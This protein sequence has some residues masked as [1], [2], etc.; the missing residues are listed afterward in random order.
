MSFPLLTTKLYMPPIR[1][2]LVPRPQLMKQ[3]NEGS[4]RRLIL[5]SAPAGFGKTTL[6]S[7]WIKNSGNPVAWISLD[8]GDNDPARFL[9]YLV[10]ALRTLKEDIGKGAL[11][12]LQ[13]PQP[14]DSETLLTAL[15]NEINTLPERLVLVLDDYHLVTAKQVHNAVAFL[16]DHLPPH[17]L[18]VLATRADPPLPIARLRGRG[19][20]TELR[21]TDL[22][23]SLDEATAFLRQVTGLDLCSEDVDALTTR[24]EGWITGL[25]MAALALQAA[26]PAERQDADQVASFVQAFT[27]SNRYVLDYLV[28]EVLQRQPEKIQSF[29]LQTAILDRLTGPLCDAVLEI[30][31]WRLDANLDTAQPAISRMQY[32]NSRSPSPSQE[33]LEQL[34]A[35]NLF[36]VPLDNERRWYR[37]HRL[38]TDL[39]RKRLQYLQPEQEPILHRRASAWL[40]EHGLVSEAIG[41]AL[42]AEDYER[43]ADLIERV[44]EATLGRSELVT[45]LGWVD[46]L[47]DELVQARP[48]LGLLHAWALMW[49]GQPL[50][51]IESRLQDLDTGTEAASIRVSA[52]RSFL[53]TWQGRLSR[54]GAMAQEAL[55]Q[56][57]EG[58]FFLRSIAAWNVGISLLLSGEIEAGSQAFEEVARMGL[59]AGNVLMSVSAL[60]HLAELRMSQAAYRE[61]EG[62]YRRALQS[63]LDAQGRPLP[64]GG[65]AL[66]GLGEISREWNELETA[67]R[68]VTEGIECTSRWGDFG[69]LDGYIAMARIRQAQ[70]DVQG[71]RD[72]LQKAQRIALLF[73]VTDLDDLVVAIHQVRLWLAQGDVE[74]AVHWLA[75]RGYS[76]AEA[77]QTRAEVRLPE[78]E[79]ADDLI[80]RHMRSYEDLLMART[81]LALD[82]P[83]DALPLLD[84]HI[85][86]L[87]QQGRR[88]SRRM[89]EVLSQKAL[90][91][92]AQGDV[93][94]A[95]TC[96]ESALS[97]A[98]PGGLMRIFVDEGEPML[99]LLRQAAARGIALGYVRQLI[100]AYDL[101][102]QAGMGRAPGDTH[103]PTQ[104]MQPLVEPLSKREM[105]VLRLLATGMS[106]PEIANEL[107]IATSTVRSHLKNIY[108]KLDVHKRW[109]A[110]HR[111]EELGLL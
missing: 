25:Q 19:Q 102:A 48:S 53:A 108:G 107:Y 3:L 89:I 43:G 56:L 98:E 93:D 100:A 54:A 9:A 29:L 91:L 96:L 58:E 110:V 55:E 61:A 18:V 103:T 69:A 21:Q 109:D 64:I 97:I 63:A 5:I 77:P 38:F 33:I 35:A 36:I 79:K 42:S 94:Q 51:S 17:V 68:Y 13:S 2:E 6:I 66:I 104:I 45:F 87:E 22:R 34:E 78:L 88:R 84:Q 41:H 10:A 11:T 4:H 101:P 8:E 105:D 76:L 24:T 74:A 30:G 95:L 14:P 73:D 59:K 44:A 72:S 57:P 75:E 26:V 1:P 49:S 15:I 82:R 23:F 60:C 37:Y 85:A 65:M 50:A 46:A 80:N 71:A 62:I 83:A 39:L 47:P 7:A 111:A 99:Q 106:N 20:L 52:L 31:D 27:G 12:A 92:Q 32:P 70:S 81:L 16:L 28:E 86:M 40:E 90:A 67:T